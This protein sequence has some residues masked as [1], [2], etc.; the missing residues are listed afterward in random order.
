MHYQLV[1]PSTPQKVKLISTAE[2]EAPN[3]HYTRCYS[4]KVNSWHC[5]IKADEYQFNF[6]SMDS[7][8]ELRRFWPEI[9]YIELC[10][11]D[12]R[13]MYLHLYV[14]QNPSYPVTVVKFT[15]PDA[16]SSF[17][18][19][20]IALEVIQLAVEDGFDENGNFKEHSHHQTNFEIRSICHFFSHCLKSV[21]E[22]IIYEPVFSKVFLY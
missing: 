17:V 6:I 8:H 12:R 13:L 19:D 2:V 7:N 15:S 1:Q 5:A 21:P 11:K 14:V 16:R 22:N 20:C 3:A 10:S 9:S 18:N 4:A